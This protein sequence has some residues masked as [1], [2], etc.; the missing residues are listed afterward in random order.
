MYLSLSLSLP[1]SLSFL[2]HLD[3]K[4]REVGV[5][6]S[7]GDNLSKVLA[8]GDRRSLENKFITRVMACLTPSSLL[9]SE[10]IV[11]KKDFIAF[12]DKGL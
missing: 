1:L 3:G 12:L 6:G 9:P 11:G 7:S 5:G 8:S 2:S 4:H 10:S